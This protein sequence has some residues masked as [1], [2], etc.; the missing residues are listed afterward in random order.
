M[1]AVR[2]HP[3][4]EFANEVTRA[5][6]REAADLNSRGISAPSQLIAALADELEERANE[7]LD[8]ELTLA[9]AAEISGY[10]YSTLE[11]QVRMGELPNAG[12]KGRPRLRRRDLP[13]KPGHE[14]GS[15]AEQRSSG[16]RQGEQTREEP[17]DQMIEEELLD[18][19]GGL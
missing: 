8:D 18:L 19:E 13:R 17:G 16:L 14:C 12:E 7:W 10:A 6:R 4:A 11:H 9:E 2:I 15:A 1:C 5:W 3:V